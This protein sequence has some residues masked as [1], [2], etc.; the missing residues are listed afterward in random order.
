[1]ECWQIILT[2][3]G[4]YLAAML[5]IRRRVTPD[6]K[7]S[8]LNDSD[9]IC[10]AKGKV[11][12]DLRLYLENV[13]MST[14]KRRF[15]FRKKRMV[16]DVCPQIFLHHQ[17]FEVYSI[18]NLEGKSTKSTQVFR[19]P[20]E[21]PNVFIPDS[22]GCMPPKMISVHHGEK[23]F[24]SLKV[25]TPQADGKYEIT[26]DITSREGALSCNLLFIICDD[27]SLNNTR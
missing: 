11:I 3:I 9:T 6:I 7:A 2:I 25:K 21:G 20:G 4:I 24:C 12:E 23:V 8:F 10:A 17:E 22:F 1:M 15:C 27:H 14:W 5:P 19:K 26:F 18:E 13:G 16:H